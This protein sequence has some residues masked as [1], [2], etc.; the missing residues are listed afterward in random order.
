MKRYGPY[1]SNNGHLFWVYIEADG[2]RRSDW[3][4]REIMEQ[5][6]GRPLLPNEVVHHLDGDKKNN[7]PNNLL[8]F[9]SSTDHSAHHAIRKPLTLV[10]LLCH[11]EFQRRGNWERSNRKK[12]KEGPFCSKSC[13]GKWS[14]QKQIA[15][16]LCN[17][18]QAHV[19]QSA[20]E[21]ASNPV[22]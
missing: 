1:E 10:C 5:K 8:L 4:H 3:V 7:N 17:L 18:R 6:L 15:S 21:T 13:A 16:G 12:G 14:R 2:S 20:E 9:A 22:K 11:T 19:S